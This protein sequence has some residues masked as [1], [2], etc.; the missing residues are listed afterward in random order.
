LTRILSFN[1]IQSRAFVGL[2]TE[3]NTLRRNLYIMGLIGRPFLRDVGQKRKPQLT[4]CVSVK[5]WQHSDIPIWV[6]FSMDPED[7]RSLTLRAIWNFIQGT[8]LLWFGH[9]FKRHKT[10]FR[11]A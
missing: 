6:P 8:R 5:P 9:Q 10:P 3:H 7:V 11:K 2:L 4:F 1:R